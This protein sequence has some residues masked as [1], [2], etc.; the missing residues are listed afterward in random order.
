MQSVHCIVKV[1]EVHHE[2]YSYTKLNRI[3][4]DMDILTDHLASRI[5]KISPNLYNYFDI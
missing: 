1:W 3:F 2:R 5:I 4:T